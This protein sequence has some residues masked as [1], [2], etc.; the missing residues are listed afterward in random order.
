MYLLTTA[1]QLIHKALLS[2]QVTKHPL[3]PACLFGMAAELSN[4]APHEIKS[5]RYA[6]EPLLGQRQVGDRGGIMALKPSI[7]AFL[8][9]GIPIGCPDWCDKGFLHHTVCI[10]GCLT[11]QRQHKSS[12]VVRTVLLQSKIHGQHVHTVKAPGDNMQA[13]MP[14][15]PKHVSQHLMGVV[16]D[17]PQS[18]KLGS[19]VQHM[20]PM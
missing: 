17:S 9:I 2:Q 13:H 4:Q 20:T 12:S 5:I 8:F 11:Q 7:D 1:T 3:F 18:P 10:A 16:N 15:L 14:N 6:L 19:V